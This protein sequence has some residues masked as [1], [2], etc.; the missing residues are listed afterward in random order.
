MEAWRRDTDGP[1]VVDRDKTPLESLSE[2]ETRSTGR[3]DPL[4]VDQT[5][6]V[7]GG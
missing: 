4:T 3:Y 7:G 5:N 1:V 2:K 6:E